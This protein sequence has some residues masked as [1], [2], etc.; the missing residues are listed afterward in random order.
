MSH[1][2]VMVIAKYE[3]MIEDLLA[4]YN[5][6]IEVDPYIRRT[7]EEMIRDS[8]SYAK[9]IKELLAEEPERE[10][11]QWDQ[12]YLDA[13]TDEDFYEAKKEED[14]LYDDDGNELSTYNPKS[15]W[16]WYE[17][18]G[19]WR[20]GFKTK[21]GEKVNYCKIK[22]LDTSPDKETYDSCVRFWEVIIEGDTPKEGEDFHTFYGKKYYTDRYRDKYHYA[23]NSSAFS[24][25][26]VVTPDGEWHE[27]GQMGWWGLSD[28]DGEAEDKWIEGFQKMI[29]EADPEYY[30]YMVDC[31]I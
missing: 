29:D 20:G 27:R 25:F 5:E 3:D 1:F 31:H 4:P 6:N 22:D 30:V 12:A 14:G 2:S 28:D 7:K 23:K 18:G 8:K 9:R 19:R 17:I 21:D 26:A 15:K 24:T 11:S 13:K 10:L 16:D